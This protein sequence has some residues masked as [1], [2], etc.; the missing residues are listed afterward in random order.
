MPKTKR[1]LSFRPMIQTHF[2]GCRFAITMTCTQKQV[3]EQTRAAI[4]GHLRQISAPCVILPKSSGLATSIH[5]MSIFLD[6]VKHEPPLCLLLVSAG[7]AVCLPFVLAR[8]TSIAPWSE[9]QSPQG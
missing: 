8:L 3:A 5:L 2:P 4:S 6:F 7:S 9:Q 1:V